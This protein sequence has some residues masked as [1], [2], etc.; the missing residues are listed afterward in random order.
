MVYPIKRFLWNHGID[1][2]RISKS[3]SAVALK[4]RYLNSSGELIVLDVG[5]NRGQFAMQARKIFG[6]KGK[7]FSFEPIASVY[8]VLKNAT[9]NDKQWI[10]L[11]YALGSENGKS[12]INISKNSCSSSI[13]DILP[14]H[15]QAEPAAEYV[16]TEE[17]EIRT[18]DSVR[19]ELGIDKEKLYLKLDAQGYE[20]QVLAGAKET[21]SNVEAIQI[22]MSLRPMYKG[23]L[24]F[25]KMC[26][27]L[28]EL[29]FVLALVEN[30]FS[31]GYTSELMQVDGFFIKKRSL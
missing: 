13:L 15:T 22:E 5:A 25:Y 16:T 29:G 20:E 7:I 19:T 6:F 2:C 24:P 27:H 31:D 1:I 18:L 30:G 11:N 14:A 3:N 4:Y 28:Q 26:E 23:E 10:A 12:C 17:I 8:T 21:L 9:I